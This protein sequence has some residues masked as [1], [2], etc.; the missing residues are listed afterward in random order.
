[1]EDFAQSP[2]EG[3]VANAKPGGRG[4]FAGITVALAG[5][6]VWVIV[7]NHYVF[8]WNLRRILS[9]PTELALLLI[10]LAG[11]VWWDYAQSEWWRRRI[12]RQEEVDQ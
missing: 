5:E 6:L 9:D 10:L 3:A 7:M 11:G 2:P 1:M 12:K 4:R 8:H